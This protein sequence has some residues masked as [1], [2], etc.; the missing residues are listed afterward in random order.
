MAML[1]M[2]ADPQQRTAVLGFSDGS[3]RLLQLCADGWRLLAAVKPHKV[4]GGGHNAQ[5]RCAPGS[6]EHSGSCSPYG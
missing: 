4:R 6:T 5:Q 2:S 3:V 1:P